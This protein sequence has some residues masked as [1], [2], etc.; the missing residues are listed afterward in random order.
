MSYK[1]NWDEVPDPI[2]MLNVATVTDVYNNAISYDNKLADHIKREDIALIEGTMYF[3]NSMQT[4]ILGVK[5][6]VI[7]AYVCYFQIF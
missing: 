1:I 6:I 2:M 7:F 5:L 4:K 3:L